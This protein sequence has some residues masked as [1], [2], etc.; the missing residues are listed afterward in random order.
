[1]K[2]KTAITIAIICF[3]ISFLGLIAIPFLP[4]NNVD[5]KCKKNLP[6]G[7]RLVVN[8]LNYY[9]PQILCVDNLGNE[10]WLFLAYGFYEYHAHRAE[11]F[12]DSCE[13]KSAIFKYKASRNIDFKP[14]RKEK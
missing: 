11:L 3:V 1:M 2:F 5:D 6:S 12:K 9:A 13:A 10:E 14:V 7:S 4:E 8:S